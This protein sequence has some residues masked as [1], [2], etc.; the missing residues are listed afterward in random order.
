MGEVLVIVYLVLLSSVKFLFVPFLS[1]HV[2]DYNFLTASIINISGALMGI[3]FFFKTSTYFIER[4]IRKR[5][6]ALLKGNQKPKKVFTKVNRILVR[7]KNTM[8]MYGLAFLSFHFYP[9]L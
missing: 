1:V 6:E 3:T 5:K 8:G 4:T 9:Y 7:V 2:H